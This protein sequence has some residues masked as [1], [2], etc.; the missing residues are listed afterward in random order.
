MRVIRKIEGDVDFTMKT[1][2]P[3]QNWSGVS[4]APRWVSPLVEPEHVD[5]EGG[6]E[7]TGSSAAMPSMSAPSEKEKEE[8][9]VSHF[10]FRAWCE[11]CVRGKAKAM[12]HVKVDHSEEQVPVISVDYC[13]MNSKEDTVI[14]DEA[15][16][17]HLPVLVVRDRWT[18][19]CFLTRVTLQG[20]SERSLW[21]QVSF[22]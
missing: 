4:R 9:F 7:P 3:S 12:R 6:D 21:I 14:T 8:H 2:Q 20:S 17:K 1:P 10:P 13:F 16:S 5:E 11:H 18:K 15:Q 22:E 19:N